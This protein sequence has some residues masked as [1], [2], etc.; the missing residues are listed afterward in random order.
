MNVEFN[1]IVLSADENPTYIDFWPLVARAYQKM[2]PQIPVHLALVSSRE[3]SDPYIA[4][5]REYGNVTIYKPVQD[6]PIFNQAKMARHFFA[7]EQGDDVCYLDD[8]DLFPLSRDFIVNKVAGRPKDH[9]LCV[10]AEFFAYGGNGCFS[11][12]QMTAE[13]NVFKRLFNPKDLPFDAFLRQ[14]VKYHARDG[15]RRNDRKEDISNTNPPSEAF[16]PCFSD[17]YLIRA[18]LLEKRVKTFHQPRGFDW[19][20][21]TVDRAWWGER[22]QQSKL[23]NHEYIYAHCV[24]PYKG[25]EHLIQPLID[26]VEK[27]Y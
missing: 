1:K 9:L 21:Q 4:K 20:T 7:S 6:I 2:F 10:G 27:T 24:R 22:F 23:D 17:E 26:Y 16:G 18:L 13:G 3:E 5:L 14:F 11:I 12:S 15:Y 19:E 25:N 8:I